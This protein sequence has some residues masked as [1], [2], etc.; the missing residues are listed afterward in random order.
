MIEE[1]RFAADARAYSSSSIEECRNE[2]RAILDLASGRI[3]ESNKQ[4]VS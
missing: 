3:T 2:V 4:H 1:C